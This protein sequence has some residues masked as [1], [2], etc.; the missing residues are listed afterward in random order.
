MMSDAGYTEKRRRMV[1]EISREFEA[2]ERSTGLHRLEPEIGAALLTVPRHEFV[3][4]PERP[5]AYRNAPLPIGAGQT[6]SQPFIVALMTQ[7]ASPRPDSRVLEVGAGS[8]YQCAVLALLAAQV[9][10][11]ELEPGLARQAAARMRELGYDNVRIR[12]GDG[13]QGW[14]EEAPFD[15]I[16]IAAAAEDVPPALLDQLSPGGRIVAPLGTRWRSQHL[17]VIEKDPEGAIHSRPILPVAFVPF[18]DS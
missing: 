2:T 11:I 8:G 14:P 3:P 1:D 9:F 5:Y 13:H 17:T 10:G 6:I 12:Q 7:L 18:R 15:A 4:V 16:L